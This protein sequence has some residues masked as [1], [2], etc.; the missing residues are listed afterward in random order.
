MLIWKPYCVSV[1]VPGTGNAAPR[2]YSFS[3]VSACV[4]LA[5]KSMVGRWPPKATLTFARAT[6]ADRRL[7][8]SVRFWSRE[9]W[10]HW[11]SLAGTGLLSCMLS[12]GFSSES[13]FWPVI[14]SS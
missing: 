1:F 8:M 13:Y 11:S 12:P 4:R 7:A 5:T 2:K 9:V 10:T 3:I 6:S 14:S